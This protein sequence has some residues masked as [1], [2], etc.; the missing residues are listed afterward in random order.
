LAARGHDIRWS[1]EPISGCQAIEIDR[2]RGVLRSAS[3]H[4]KDD[5][6]LGF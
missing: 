4:R 5:L 3:D 6:A 1:E 2:G